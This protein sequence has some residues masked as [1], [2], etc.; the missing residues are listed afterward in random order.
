MYNYCVD[1]AGDT[2]MKQNDGMND[3]ATHFTQITIVT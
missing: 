2:T 3:D 1:L